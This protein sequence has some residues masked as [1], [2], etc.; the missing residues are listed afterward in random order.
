[1]KTIYKTFAWHYLAALLILLSILSCSKEDSDAPK[2]KSNAILKGTVSSTT[3]ATKTQ[4]E[5]SDK[6]LKVRWNNGDEIVVS[7]GKDLFKF[8]QTGSLSD[9][10]HTALFSSENPVSFG[11]GEIIA[12]YPYTETLSY[13]LTKQAGTID[14]LFQSDLLLARANVTATKVD[15]LAFLPLC[16]VIRFPKDIL[17][18]DEDYSGEMQ[19]TISGDNVGG[20]VVISKTGGIEVQTEGIS[21]PVKI[22]NG[23]FAEDAYVVFVPKENTG[24]FSY[25]L[26]T[27]RDDFY[28]FTIENITTTSIYSVKSVFNGFVQFEDPNF[29]KYCLENFDIDGDGEISLAEAKRVKKMSFGTSSTAYNIS[30]LRGIEFFKNLESLTCVGKFE[31]STAFENDHSGNITSLDLSQNKH[32]KKLHCEYN[33]IT[34][35]NIS[36]CYELTD[37]QCKCNYISSLELEGLDNIEF[38]EC[39]ENQ[40]A[41]LELVSHNKLEILECNDNYLT[42]L[43]LDGID[44]LHYLKCDRNNLTYLSLDGCSNLYWLECY[45]NQISSI[46]LKDCYTLSTF[47][48]SNNNLTSINLKDCHNLGAFICSDNPITELDLKD[49]P[50]LGYLACGNTQLRSLDLKEQKNLASLSCTYNQ[51]DIID[52]EGLANL[53]TIVLTG[54]KL[55]TAIFKGC[56]SLEEIDASYWNT[57]LETIDVSDCTSLK[58][59]LVYMGGNLKTLLVNN[60]ES[61]SELQCQSN[62]LEQL[63]VSTCPLL[64]RL[65]CGTNQLEELDVSHNQ[66]LVRLSCGSNKLTSL[67]VSNNDNLDYLYCYENKITSLDLKNNPKINTLYCTDNQLSYLNISQCSNLSSLSCELNLLTELDVSNNKNLYQLFCSNNLITELSITDFPLLKDFICSDNKLTSLVVSNCPSLKYISCYNN[68]LSELNVYTC[69]SLTAI[70]AWPQNTTLSTLY[71]KKGQTI[72]YYDQNAKLIN[73]NNYGTNIVE[74]D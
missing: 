14:K 46:N 35:L 4:H 30:S 37:L 51:M 67:D 25:N 41:K 16:A 12:I 48:C 13:D 8:A 62:K 66:K 17:V 65:A 68:A 60:C 47:Y 61:L 27:D 57:N 5:Y 15:D 59:L 56:S 63:D 53:K 7:D 33:K 54:T 44:S 45:E 10:G 71:V 74:V 9:D 50:N 69:T 20:K 42:T 31:Y 19:I 21:I 43:I 24:S 73:P 55:K 32:I 49:C 11:E 6:T 58:K 22:S 2:L 18:T 34:S 1:M 39:S 3:P 36:G 70:Y 64:E 26:E 23:K 72:S 40:I 52:C 28:S 29:K 38:I